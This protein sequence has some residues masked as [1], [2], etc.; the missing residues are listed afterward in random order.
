MATSTLVGE[1]V[2]TREMGR[3]MTGMPAVVKVPDATFDGRLFMFEANMPPGHVIPPH[4]HT[5]EDE[6]TIVLE[7]ELSVELGGERTV[8]RTGWIVLKPRGIQ[9]S[10]GNHSDSLVRVL[11][12]HLPGRLEPYYEQLGKLF[13]AEGLDPAERARAVNELAT[14][15]GVTFAAPPGAPKR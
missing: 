1:H 9:H 6:L 14:R 2:I 10:I 8:A 7:G 3:A 5:H 11:E 15:Y 13:V 4:T 12:L